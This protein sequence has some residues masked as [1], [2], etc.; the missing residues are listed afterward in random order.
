MNQENLARRFSAPPSD[1]LSQLR[2]MARGLQNFDG[3]RNIQ[4]SALDCRDLIQHCNNRRVLDAR[5]VFE[6][7]IEQGV[8]KAIFTITLT[9]RL[10][11]SCIYI[12]TTINVSGHNPALNFGEALDNISGGDM[13]AG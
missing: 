7:M 11:N 13:A 1:I 2:R 5:P 9:G 4:I 10:R 3:E 8:P 12:V 6:E